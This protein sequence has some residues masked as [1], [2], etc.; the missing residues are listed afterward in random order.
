MSSKSLNDNGKNIK[1]A[2]IDLDMSY[3][4]LAREMGCSVY[5]IREIVAGTR[6]ATEMRER[7]AKYFR[8][9]YR[10]YGTYVPKWIESKGRV[11]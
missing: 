7:I 9:Q 3:L 1:K 5:Y 4:D 10:K 11:A 6:K 2:L 8:K